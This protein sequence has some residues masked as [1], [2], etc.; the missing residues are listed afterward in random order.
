MVNMDGH[1]AKLAGHTVADLLSPKLILDGE[2][3]V[4]VFFLGLKS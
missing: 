3:S 2:L 4:V 1:M